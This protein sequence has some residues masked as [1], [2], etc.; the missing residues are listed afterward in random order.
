MVA[1]GVRPVNAQLF[2]EER[3]LH[4]VDLLKIGLVHVA[5]ENDEIGPQFLYF[6]HQHPYGFIVA[7]RR[8]AAA[9]EGTFRVQMQVCGGEDPELAGIDPAVRQVFCDRNG[10]LVLRND[11]YAGADVL[12]LRVLAE[13]ELWPS[14]AG[15]P[16]QQAAGRQQGGN[17][18]M[19]QISDRSVIWIL[20]TDDPFSFLSR[21]FLLSLFLIV[22][23][24]SFF[25]KTEL[26][27]LKAAVLYAMLIPRGCRYVY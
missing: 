24:P 14:A 4:R 8:C 2:H 20:H 3:E 21:L 25:F 13:Q 11:L 1:E 12:R 17:A 10:G 19:P 15:G 9:G 22:S 7:V 26:F 6:A 27:L 18:F 5:C 16:V 23:Q